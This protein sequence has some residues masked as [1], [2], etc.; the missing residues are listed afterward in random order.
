MWFRINGIAFLGAWHFFKEKR[1]V[2]VWETQPLKVLILVRQVDYLS[3]LLQLENVRLKYIQWTQFYDWAMCHYISTHQK[4]D[5]TRSRVRWVRGTLAHFPYCILCFS[6][7]PRV[8]VENP[9]IRPRYSHLSSGLITKNFPIS[10]NRPWHKVQ[11]TCW[12][13]FGQLHPVT[14]TS[15]QLPATA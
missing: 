4:Q 11:T 15:V 12:Y 13:N 8:A 6:A 9:K 2:A 1:A 14:P 5:Q 10:T 3:D 7:L